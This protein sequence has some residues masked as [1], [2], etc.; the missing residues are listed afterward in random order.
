M[1]IFSEFFFLA[2]S[3]LV[4]LHLQW[5]FKA[6]SANTRPLLRNKLWCVFTQ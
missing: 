6:Y 1:A 2:L 5:I 4:R 3:L